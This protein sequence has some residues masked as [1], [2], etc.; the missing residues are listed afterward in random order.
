MLFYF[1]FISNIYLIQYCNNAQKK[2]NN[3]NPFKIDRR[4]LDKCTI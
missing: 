4:N 1:I 3:P 2:K